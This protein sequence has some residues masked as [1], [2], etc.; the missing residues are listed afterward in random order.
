ME[1]DCII[2]LRAVDV[3]DPETG[4]TVL[5]KS[6]DWQIAP[7]QFWVVGGAPGGGKS[8][9]LATAAGLNRPGSGT[10]RIFGRNLTEATESEQ[11]NW[12]RRIGF[13][14]ENG[15]RLLAQ[16][17]I[18][19]NMALP[20]QYHGDIAG[21]NIETAVESWLTTTELNT[22]AEA[23]PS[24]LP[25]RLQQRV[26]LARAV[27][28]P[29]DILFVD[30]PFVA[31]TRDARWWREQLTVLARQGMTIVVASNDFRAWLDTAQQFALVHDGQFSIIG[32]A[33]HVRTATDAAW[34]EYVTVN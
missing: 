14:F 17:S 10:L 33:E 28:T 26:S 2:E 15:G 25:P 18:A 21:T 4:D 16:L 24:R 23:M 9:L 29:K 19:E 34:R 7:G 31:G 13:V 6:V 27:I 3:T 1:N 5:V 30:T 32:G 11:I 20:L 8:S 22:Y 12:R